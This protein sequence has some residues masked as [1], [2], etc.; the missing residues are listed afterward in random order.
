MTWKQIAD[1]NLIAAKSLQSD[2]RWRSSVSRSYYAAYAEVTSELVGRTSFPDDRQGP[3][4]HALPK[5]IMTYLAMIGFRDRKS[6]AATAHRLYMARIDADYIASA[7]VEQRSARSAVQDASFV[8][9]TVR[10]ANR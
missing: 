4:H 6:V 9:R 10:H 3:S 7:E 5:L 1:D 2:G 8:L